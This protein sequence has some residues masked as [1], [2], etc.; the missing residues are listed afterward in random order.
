MHA[1]FMGEDAARPDGGGLLIFRH[2]DA[3]AFEIG[4]RVDPGIGAHEDAG[5][6]EFARREHRQR[7]PGRRTARRGD[8]KRRH[9]H[10][11]HVEIPES[12]LTPKHLGRM[13]CGRDEP[14]ALRLDAAVE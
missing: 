13:H 11:G 7:H 10:F 2:A 6:K 5:V 1:E 12:Q 9:R 14:D 8:Q 4:G 3:L